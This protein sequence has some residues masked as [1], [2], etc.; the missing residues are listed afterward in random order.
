M[1][2]KDIKHF[3]LDRWES[4]KAPL[5]KI[6]EDRNT[7]V[8]LVDSEKEIYDFDKLCSSLFPE[9]QKPASADGLE[10]TCRDVVLIEFKSGF[11]KKISKNNLDKEKAVCE[12]AKK[13]C[14]DYWKLFFQKQ[15]LETRELIASLRL[16]AIESFLTLDKKIVP[17]CDDTDSPV[18]IKFLAV[19]DSDP[20]ECIE[21][22]LMEVSEK[23]SLSNNQL[24]RVRN[25]LKRFSNQKDANGNIYCY[26]Y[27][28]V[29]SFQ[30]YNQLIKS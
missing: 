22:I 24:N 2:K 13:I 18:R 5:S 10:I 15:D 21:D 8:A 11:K 9:N 28:D 16:K 1:I 27:I 29:I 25:S 6:S 17:L 23:P 20:A 14:E 4:Y 30:E 26:D 7:H 19:I 3:A 12:E